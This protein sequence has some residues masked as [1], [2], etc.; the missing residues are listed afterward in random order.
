MSYS[1]F[2]QPEALEELSQGKEWYNLREEG[3]GDG[4][5]DEIDQVLIS[6]SENPMIGPEVY[7]GLRRRI[8]RRF[9]YLVLYKVESNRVN[10]VAIFHAS[11]DPQKWKE[12]A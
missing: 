6:I 12:R 5:E 4:L 9:P 10:I 2:L 11:Q 3:L 1:I 7:R 8:L